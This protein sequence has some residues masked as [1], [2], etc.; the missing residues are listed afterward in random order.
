MSA[1][2]LIM[3]EKTLQILLKK[4]YYKTHL[5]NRVTIESPG[6]YIFFWGFL[7]TIV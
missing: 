6:N 4:F 7:K 5:K 3:F 2:Y 1:K